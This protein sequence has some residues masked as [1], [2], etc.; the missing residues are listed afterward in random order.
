MKKHLYYLKAGLFFLAP[1]FL[2]IGVGVALVAIHP[3]LLVVAGL[4][5]LAWVIGQIL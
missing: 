2:I 1:V 5:V 3:A 4:F